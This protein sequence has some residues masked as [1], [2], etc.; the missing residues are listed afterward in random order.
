MAEE[1]MNNVPARDND[2]ATLDAAPRRR[3]ALFANLPIGVRIALGF[4]VV[5]AVLAGLSVNAVSNVTQTAA[6]TGKLHH[7]P[8]TV[9]KSLG[10][11]RFGVATLHVLAYDAATGVAKV[12]GAKLA[13]TIT[14]LRGALELAGERYLGPKKDIQAV[15]DAIAPFQAAVEK[16]VALADEGKREEALKLY[17]GEG[18]GRFATATVSVNDMITFAAN[19][20]QQFVDTSMSNK[21]QLVRISWVALGIAL[22]LCGLVAVGTSR[23]ITHPLARLRGQMERLAKGDVDL[24]VFGLGRRDEIGAMATTVAVFKDDLIEKQ[25]FEAEAEAREARALEDKRRTL[26]AVADS[27]EARVKT[28]VESVTRAASEMRGS[29]QGLST[30]A[31]ETSRRSTAVAAASEQATQ[32]VQTVA[33]ATEELSA[34]V[35]EIGLQVTQSTTMIASAVTQANDSNAQVQ[36][37]TTA[38]QKIGEVVKIIADIAGQTNLLALNATIEA[39]RAGDAGKG[40]AVVASEVKALANQTA[41]ATDEIAAQIKAIQEATATS[42]RSIHDITETIGRVNET[43]TTIASAVEQQGAAT[44]EIARNVSEAS[45]GTQEVSENIGGVSQAAG[46]AGA[47]AAQVLAAAGELSRSGDLLKTQIDEFL[48][49]VRVA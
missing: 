39:A 37:L 24:E 46:D 42:A 25:R 30:T 16:I 31:E 41:R 4:A 44:Q 20:A 35:K 2:R 40:F 27:F 6:A 45:R 7:H 29:A 8:F 23:G 9:I 14:G 49:E 12:D 21:D 17:Q 28:V 34:S 5:L 38:A 3:F 1:T 13:D 10:E 26:N 11:A 19:K 18:R 32:N 43:A 48:R 47:A 36:G 33:S 15:R 22:A